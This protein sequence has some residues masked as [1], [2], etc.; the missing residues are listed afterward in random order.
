LKRLLTAILV[1]GLLGLLGARYVFVGSW[2]SL[3]PWSIAGLAIG[4]WSDDAKW[5][6]AGSLYGF[7][8]LFVFM[9]AGY[10]GAASTLSRLPFFAII[11]LAGALYGVILGLVAVRLRRHLGSP[12]GGDVA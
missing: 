1:G 10:A 2:L 7:A 6:I 3:I 12:R 4:Y 9:I 5:A 11:G 8:L